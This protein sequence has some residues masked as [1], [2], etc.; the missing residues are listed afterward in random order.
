MTNQQ[1]SQMTTKQKQVYAAK[2]FSK[3]CEEKGIINQSINELIDHLISIENWEN[4]VDWENKGAQLELAGRGDEIPE[5]IDYLISIKDKS[6]FSELLESVVE[7]GITDMYG[8]ETE[9][10]TLYLKK[11][12]AILEKNKITIPTI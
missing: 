2:C 6:S 1:I 3:Y 5:S 8:A 10:P 9:D 7:V 4:I 12:I 11:C